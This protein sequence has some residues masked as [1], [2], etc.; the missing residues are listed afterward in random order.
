MY[1]YTCIYYSQWSLELEIQATFKEKRTYL[2]TD[3][4]TRIVFLISD[5]YNYRLP[6]SGCISKLLPHSISDNW[7]VRERAPHI[8]VER[9][10]S[11]HDYYGMSVTLIPLYILY[12]STRYIPE[13]A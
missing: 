8:R 4:F 10:Q 1:N 6:H 12:S 9:S 11:I 7:G 5:D 3:Q 13:A 2:D